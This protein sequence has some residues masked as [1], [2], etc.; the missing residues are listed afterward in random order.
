MS[1]VYSGLGGRSLVY[2]KAIAVFSL[3]CFVKLMELQ[4]SFQERG[5]LIDMS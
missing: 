4:T 3:I 2:F 5:C 1:L